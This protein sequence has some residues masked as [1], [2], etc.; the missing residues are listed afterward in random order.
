LV[1]DL[2]ESDGKKALQ[3]RVAALRE[4]YD[5]INKVYED[6][7]KAKGIHIPRVTGE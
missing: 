2:E 7:T 5:G 4:R 1:E 6:A 3:A